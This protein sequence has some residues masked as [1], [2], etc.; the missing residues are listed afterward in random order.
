MMLGAGE[1]DA[2]LEEVQ[3][4]R[5]AITVQAVFDSGT[6]GGV[7]SGL[8]WRSV[9]FGEGQLVAARIGVFDESSDEPHEQ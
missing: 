6:A 4:D 9:G 1:I 7:D 2:V 3:V 5:E 8:R